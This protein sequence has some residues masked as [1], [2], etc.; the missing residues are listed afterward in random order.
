MNNDC[1]TAPYICSK[2]GR[3]IGNEYTE[4]ISDGFFVDPEFLPACECS[5]TCQAKK[6]ESI[7]D[8]SFQLTT[9]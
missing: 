5:D 6:E 3:I 8:S 1:S 9:T 7:I 4:F 2:T